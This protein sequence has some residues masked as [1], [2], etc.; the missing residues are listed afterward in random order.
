MFYTVFN[1]FRQYVLKYNFIQSVTTTAS[2]VMWSTDPWKTCEDTVTIWHRWLAHAS[3]EA[4]LH[5]STAVTRVKLKGLLT[6]NCE[7]YAVSKLY[8]IISRHPHHRS[9][10]PYECIHLDIIHIM[11]AYNDESFFIYFLCDC[12]Q[13]N[14]VT[15]LTILNEQILLDRITTFIT[16]IKQ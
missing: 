6:I 12:T 7:S 14:H 10:T 9:M 13:M 8:R 2:F 11:K 1:K 16:Y 5:L 3:P 15:G 4:L